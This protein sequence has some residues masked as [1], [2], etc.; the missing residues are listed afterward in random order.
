MGSN[1]PLIGISVDGTKE[2]DTGREYLRVRPTYVDAILA[3]GGIPVL[4]PF[5]PDVERLRGMFDR[6]DG[7][8]LTGGGDMNPAMYHAETAPK[9]NGIL[10]K[11]D[12]AEIEIVRWAVAEE[13]PLLA[14]CRGTQV[15][16][17]T[18]GGT[19][20]QDIKTEV[21]GALWHDRFSTPWFY[22]TAH[23]VDIEAGSRL[24]DILKAEGNRTPVN[25]LH[26]QAL[27]TVPDGLDIV[28]HADD[29][30]IEA[31]EN[32]DHRFLVGVQWHPETLWPASDPMRRLFA[33]FVTAASW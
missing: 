7:I 3:G 4:I 25:S 1:R 18:H 31:V 5:T 11:R 2:S 33:A 9:T 8:L 22:R 14:I 12:T 32:A 28:A 20:I 19:L 23:E 13:K 30:V 17:V 6:L 21:R 27:K 15:L 10:E 26:H 29:G 16:T 24:G